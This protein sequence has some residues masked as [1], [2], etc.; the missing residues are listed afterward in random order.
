MAQ[1]KDSV[2]SGNLAVTDDAYIGHVQI[3]HVFENGTGTIG[4]DAGSGNSPRYFPSKWVFDGD[5]ELI[6]GT[7]MLIRIPVAGFSAGVYLS[8]DGGNTFAP[9]MYGDNDRLQTQFPVGALLQLIYDSE[10]VV[11]VY[12]IEGSD[13]TTNITGVWRTM[14]MYNTNTTYSVMGT[15][16]VTAG[17]ASSSRV[18]QARYLSAGLKAAIKK[19]SNVVPG[20]FTV[21][22][23]VVDTL[24][25]TASD[26]GKFLSVVNGVPTWVS[27]AS[28]SGVSF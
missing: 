16:E 20:Q 22:S 13:T 1:L 24:G 25:A 15:A 27:I 26:N 21:Y 11:P 14:N 5:V 17:T 3:Q 28:A 8:M 10:G 23:Q 19:G 12:S 2:I 4:Q 7:K 18:I 9:V 6:N